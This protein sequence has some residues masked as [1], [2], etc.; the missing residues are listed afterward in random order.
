[1]NAFL[2]F[3]RAAKHPV[4]SG[5]D[6][7]KYMAEACENYE[8]KNDKD[9]AFVHIVAVLSDLPKFDSRISAQDAEELEQAESRMT[10]NNVPPMGAAMDRP[11]GSKAAKNEAARRISQERI[12]NRRQRSLDAIASGQFRMAEAANRSARTSNLNQRALMFERRGN[13]VEADR[14]L[15]EIKQLD[16]QWAI[17]DAAKEAAVLGGSRR[18][19]LESIMESEEDEFHHPPRAGADTPPLPALGGAQGGA[20]LPDGQVPQVPL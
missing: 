12:E 2:P 19:S 10:N 18:N 7:E 3:L 8:A 11:Q 16:E 5:Y 9:F 4:K 1:M 6:E 17:E 14:I 20:Q 13:F 15:E